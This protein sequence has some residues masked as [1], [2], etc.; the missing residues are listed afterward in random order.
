MPNHRA[1]EFGTILAGFFSFIVGRVAILQNWNWHE[2]WNA[3]ASV[4]SFLGGVGAVGGL[5]WVIWRFYND[6]VAKP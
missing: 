4:G 6:K 1:G 3:I 5:I 2:V